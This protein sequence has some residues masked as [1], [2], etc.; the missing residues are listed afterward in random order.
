METS[1]MYA[2]GDTIN[3]FQERKKVWMEIMIWQTEENQ[4]EKGEN[5]SETKWLTNTDVNTD[6]RYNVQ[7]TTTMDQ[8]WKMRI[9]RRVLYANW[10][11][12]PET[13]K[14]ISETIQTKNRLKIICRVFSAIS[15][16]W[17][18]I[19][20]MTPLSLFSLKG[21]I[22]WSRSSWMIQT[23]GSFLSFTFEKEPN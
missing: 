15:W 5:D 1:S 16:I 13:G 9:G 21:V 10:H 3:V 12:H 2:G 7:N 4:L 6:T 17:G 19:Q 11:N 20:G 8:Q 23:R 22:L 18:I 14:R